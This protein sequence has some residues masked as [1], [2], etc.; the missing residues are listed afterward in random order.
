[1]MRIDRFLSETGTA[2]RSD[3]KKL[4]KAGRISVNGK[5]VP[6]PGEKIDETSDIVNLDNKPILFERFSY[7]MLYKPAGCVSAARDGLSDTVLDLL[8]GEN[9]R[10]LFPVGRLDKDTEGLLLITNDGALAHEL[11][12]PK[13]HVDKTYLAVVDKE[14]SPAETEAFQNGLDIGDAKPTLPAKLEYVPKI[15]HAPEDAISNEKLAPAKPECIPGDAAILNAPEV[16]APHN[17]LTIEPKSSASYLVTIHEG[18]FHQIKRMFEA[19]G[20][21]VTYLKRLS[22][23]SLHLDESLTPGS[24]RKLTDKEISN[25]K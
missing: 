16:S 1:M 25:L 24:Y 11:L 2:S 7:F 21:N 22:M 8:K 18:R 23:G 6:D 4:I 5:V 15:V 14:L 3:A 12:S 10:D 9:T 17:S 13:K 19:L 20:A